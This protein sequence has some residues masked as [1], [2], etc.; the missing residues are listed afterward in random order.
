MQNTRQAQ[1]RST[2]A[3]STEYESKEHWL[4]A[5]VS[6]F[7]PGQPCSALGMTLSAHWPLWRFVRT[8][9]EA[10][11]FSPTQIKNIQNFGHVFV[12]KAGALMYCWRE[13][14]LESLPWRAILLNIL[15]I[16]LWVIVRYIWMSIYTHLAIYIHITQANS[17]TNSTSRNWERIT[18]MYSHIENDVS[19]RLFIQDCS[20]IS[21]A[22]HRKPP[23][24]QS[25]KGS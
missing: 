18:Q 3:M 20:C 7:W 1:M 10:S 21:E 17:L 13:H 22:W 25:V 14:K 15:C 8:L 23:K 19:T 5:G 12:I 2:Q 24:W 11:Y 4:A 6:V 16:C 9:G